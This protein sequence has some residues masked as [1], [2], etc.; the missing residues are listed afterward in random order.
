MTTPLS[1]RWLW[2]LVVFSLVVVGGCGH[3]DE[4]ACAD[5]ACSVGRCV[6]NAGLATCECGA[7]D[8]AAGLDCT[9]AELMPKGDVGGTPSTATPLAVGGA[10]SGDFDSSQGI[11]VDVYSIVTESQHV[12]RFSCSGPGTATCA[13]RL[14]NSAGEQQADNMASGAA[15]T[16]KVAPGRWFLEAKPGPSQP[17]AGAYSYRL[18]DVGIDDHGDTPATATVIQSDSTPVSVSAL[19]LGD[20]DVLLIHA[21]AGHGY[22]LSCTTPADH[23]RGGVELRGTSEVAYDWTTVNMGIPT[24]VSFL[25]KSNADYLVSISGLTPGPG[26]SCQLR[27]VA[28]DHGDSIA[29]A[30]PVSV[31]T[32]A[33]FRMDT[34]GDQDFFAF[35][36]L[37]G[38]FYSMRGTEG[39]GVINAVL[40]DAASTPVA[41]GSVESGVF[42]PGVGMELTY[43][44]KSSGTYYLRIWPLSQTTRDAPWK[45]IVEDQ[46]LR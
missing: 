20:V 33:S 24:Q 23:F 18:E 16:F 3:V 46:G 27:D 43:L 21:I 32:P 38:H 29:T 2:G 9:H 8:Q 28:D 6:S 7:D 17:P 39:T 13:I 40:L 12:Y 34:H 26:L 35:S 14:L 31:G 5:F 42:K 45:L 44:C 22:I 19:E 1:T 10:H 25:A 36:A 37:A 15:L 4:G 11:D 41:E 30:T